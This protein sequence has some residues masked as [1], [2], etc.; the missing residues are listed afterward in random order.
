[1]GEGWGVCVCVSEFKMYVHV[2]T[3][4][5]HLKAAIRIRSWRQ[6]D[7]GGCKSISSMVG[8]DVVLRREWGGQEL[9][10]QGGL[11]GLWFLRYISHFLHLL[12]LSD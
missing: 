8:G 7:G 10:K 2:Y 4:M 1:M 11:L 3:Y 5:N 9:K 12:C 6:E